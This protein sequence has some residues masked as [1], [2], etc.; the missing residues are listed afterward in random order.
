MLEVT[1]IE[2]GIVIDHIKAGYGIQLFNY[3]KLDKAEYNVALIINAFS[4]KQGRKDIIKINNEI[5]IDY[6]FLGLLDPNITINVIED[7][8]IKEKVKLNVPKRV[9]NIIKCKNPRCITSV[10]GYC[11]HVFHLVDEKKRT[12]RC[13]YCDDIVTPHINR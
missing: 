2:K 12:Y 3:L 1:S 7:G 13:E 8:K 9:V 11:D 10:E 5:D 6:T 4:K